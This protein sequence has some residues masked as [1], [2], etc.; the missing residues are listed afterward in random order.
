MEKRFQALGYRKVTLT[1][2]SILGPAGTQLRGHEFHYS[3]LISL[4][5][6]PKPD[7]IYESVDAEGNPCTSFGWTLKNALGSYVHLHFRSLAS[8]LKS[9]QTTFFKLA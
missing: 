6:A 1:K 4:S 2:D 7:Q 3:K 9:I 8:P 5:N